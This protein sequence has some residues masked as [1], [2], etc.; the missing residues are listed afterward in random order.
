M[1]KLNELRNDF[2]HFLPKVWLIEVSGL[3]DIVNDCIAI[4]E[5]LSFE[6]GNIFSS[7][8]EITKTTREIHNKINAI[9]AVYKN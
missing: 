5:L 2:I 3:P 6:S 4:I 7:Q 9:K 8:A 1:N